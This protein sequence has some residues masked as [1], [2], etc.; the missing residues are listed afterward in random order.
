[1]VISGGFLDLTRL[2]GGVMRSDLVQSGCNTSADMYEVLLVYH[3]HKITPT[4]LKKCVE[5][6]DSGQKWSFWVVSGPNPTSMT[7]YGVRP[8]PEWLQYLC[9]PV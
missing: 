1:M 5:T 9:G 7:S 3:T 8:G 2:L 4:D 6:T